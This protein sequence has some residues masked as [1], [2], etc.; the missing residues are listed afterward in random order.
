[1]RERPQA[2]K[3][4]RLRLGI[5]PACAGKTGF[6]VIFG[7]ACWDHPRMCG[8]DI[9]P[10]GTAAPGL[11]SPPHVRERRSVPRRFTFLPGITPACAGKTV[12]D[13][14][15]KRVLQ[16][17]PRMCGKDDPGGKSYGTYQGSPPHVRERLRLSVS[18]ELLSGITPACAGKTCSSAE[19]KNDF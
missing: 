9:I 15:S 5:T 4:W 12:N 11:G 7:T 18:I 16:D 10:A 1:M 14:G 6:G 2:L 8:K 13:G 17:H 19:A 3:V